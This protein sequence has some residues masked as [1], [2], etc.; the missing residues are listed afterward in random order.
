MAVERLTVLLGRSDLV[1]TIGVPP[2]TR[3]RLRACTPVVVDLDSV[4]P[5]VAL[6]PPDSGRLALVSR[7]LAD[8][9]RAA[10]L[11]GILPAVRGLVVAV[12]AAPHRHVAD[13]PSL[14]RTWSGRVTE[15]RLD[16]SPRQ[17]WIL[18][19]RFTEQTPAG[20]VLADIVRVRAPATDT[21]GLRVAMAGP[22]C[23]HWRP[24]D[25]ATSL[26]PVAGP[27]REPND[28]L[29]PDLVLRILADP[30]VPAWSDPRVRVI[31]RLA[32]DLVTWDRLGEPGAM[33]LA[34]RLARSVGGV[35]QV[36][37]VDEVCVNPIGFVRR[38]SLGIARLVQHGGQWRVV[39][40]GLP[41]VPI[42]RDGG[43]TEV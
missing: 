19:L 33:D 25:P 26:V 34:R 42:P 43:I 32:H 11:A 14:A 24:G 8:L 17:G 31:D 28:A 38:P 36:P 30:P 37:P 10:T 41:P 29:A 12:L 6:S 27:L 3:E 4:D 18:Q 1:A 7:T 15:L 9:R 21:P 35:D 23:T 39:G 16:R 22:G 5:A 20:R 2:D 40:E 13:L